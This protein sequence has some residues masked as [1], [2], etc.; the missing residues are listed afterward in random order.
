[1]LPPPEM[2]LNLGFQ[3]PVCLSSLLRWHVVTRDSLTFKHV[4]FLQ[5]EAGCLPAGTHPMGQQRLQR[6]DG[7]ELFAGNFLLLL[8]GIGEQSF[9]GHG[10]KAAHR[11]RERGGAGRS[12]PMGQN[13]KE[14]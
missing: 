5:G 3:S 10:L 1:M 9:L 4:A 2:T 6:F 8:H 14:N 7:C 11:L 12:S 13:L